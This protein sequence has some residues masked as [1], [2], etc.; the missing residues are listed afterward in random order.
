MAEVEEIVVT[1][2]RIKTEGLVANSPITTITAEEMNMGQPVSAE[3]IIKMLPAV[4][5]AIGP[6]T[7]NGANGGATI[8]LRNLG[9]ER[10]LVLLDGRRL[11]PF[12]LDGLVDTNVVP[13]QMLERADLVTGGDSA[14]YGADAVAGVVNFILKRN[15]E[16]VTASASYGVSD[17]SD[18]RR[19]RGDI[20]AG[21]NFADDRGS[22]MIG[23]GYTDSAALFQGR[24]PTGKVSLSSV[25]GNPQGSGTDRPSFFTIAPTAGNTH[26]R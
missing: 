6:G 5:P 18:A 7:N 14:V 20:I 9:E 23:L 1:G 17:E 24:R 22:V 21:G 2:S 3:E 15:Y 13:V 4:V 8:D 16:G 12:N 19:V 26:R 11:T 10:T 25:T